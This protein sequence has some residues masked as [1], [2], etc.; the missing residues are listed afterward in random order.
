[1]AMKNKNK[2]IF[3][4]WGAVETKKKPWVPT[5]AFQG[6]KGNQLAMAA[7]AHF[8]KH[9]KWEKIVDILEVGK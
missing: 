9:V 4:Q 6:T 3:V 2:N 5:L 1:M 7:A 8:R